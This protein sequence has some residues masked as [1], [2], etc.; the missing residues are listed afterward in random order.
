MLSL[1]M[2]ADGVLVTKINK[3]VSFNESSGMEGDKV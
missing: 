2:T 3:S 1:V